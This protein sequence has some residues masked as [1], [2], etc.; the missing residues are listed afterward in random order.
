MVFHGFTPLQLQERAVAEFLCHDFDMM[1]GIEEVPIVDPEAL[2][3]RSGVTSDFVWRILGELPP[4]FS[5][6]SSSKLS[7]ELFGLFSPKIHA[8]KKITPK[9]VGIPLQRHWRPTL[10]GKVLTSLFLVV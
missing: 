6:N 9:I 10:A 4:H 7:R 8:L 1:N 5:A 3:S 2:Q